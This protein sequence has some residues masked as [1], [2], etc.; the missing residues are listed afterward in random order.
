MA[1]TQLDPRFRED[2]E[3]LDVQRPRRA[4]HVGKSPHTGYCFL[5]FVPSV[6][7]VVEILG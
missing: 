2:D 4:T 3:L 6:F 5:I 7:S 1:G